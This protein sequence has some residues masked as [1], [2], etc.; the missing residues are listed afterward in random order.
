MKAEPG[1][2]ALLANLVVVG[3]QNNQTPMQSPLP[4]KLVNVLL[5]NEKLSRQLPQIRHYARRPVFDAS[6]DL[7]GPGFHAGQNILVHGP[8]IAP[9]IDGPAT[10]PEPPPWTGCPSTA[11]VL[12]RDF[13]WASDA[14]L[15]NAVGVLLT[16]L[17][18]NHFVDDPKPIA[19]LDGNQ[20]GLGKTLFVQVA[21]HSSTG[22]CRHKIALCGDEELRR[23]SARYSE[24]HSS[25]IVLLRQRAEHIESTTIEANAL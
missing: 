11:G 18:A 4:G 16:G 9:D 14:D 7:R 10:P 2:T 21:G 20:R 8:D 1:A 3:V 12:L 13:C 22:R 19:I 23:S 24:G 5:A 25:S 17:L 15:T 6:F